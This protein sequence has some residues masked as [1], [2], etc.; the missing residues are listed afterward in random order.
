[1]VDTIDVK[2][3]DDV[4]RTV[5]TI[6]I[7]LGTAGTPSTEVQTIQGIAAMT[8]ILATLSGT[9]NIAT[10]TAVTAISNALPAGNN[11]IGDVDVASIAAGDNNIGNVDVVTLPSLPAGTNNI[12]DVDVLSLP[13]LPA[14]NNNIGDVDVASLPALAAGTNTIGG[15]FGFFATATTQFTRPNDTTT[16]AP[17]EAMA[18]SDSAPTAG[19]FT[20]SNAARQ[21]GGSGIITDMVIGLSTAAATPL[22]GE[23]WIFDT[24]VTAIND[25]ATFTLSDSDRDKLVGIVPFATVSGATNNASAWV[26]GLNLG[27]TAV[28]SA[29][30]RYLVKVLN[31]YV[32]AAQEVLTVRAKILQVT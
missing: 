30:L 13:A 22:Q 6:D 20:L 31:A 29:D 12:G 27:F 23:I 2:D 14:G 10:V 5:K 16:Y 24:S 26:S 4:T 7:T 21:S 25:N 28:G 9:N 15:T 1:M 32:P 3:A 8:P 18:N 19:G 11:N 17:G